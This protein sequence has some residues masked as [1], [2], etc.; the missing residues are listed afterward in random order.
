[1]YGQLTNWLIGNK[2]AWVYL[3]PVLCIAGGEAGASGPILP[4]ISRV[5]AKQSSALETATTARALAGKG[6]FEQAIAL[7]R[8]ALKLAEQEFGPEHEYVAFIL[9][10]LAKLHYQLNS[11]EEALSES[12]RALAII[13]I[14]YPVNSFPYASLAN[15]QASILFALGRLT[16]AERL[17]R[18][19]H[20]VFVNQ[21]G[22]TDP[23]TI[24]TA[25]N[26]GIVY[27]DMS[28]YDDSESFFTKPLRKSAPL[29]DNGVAVAKAT[30]MWPA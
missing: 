21:L 22:V 6:Q 17:Y 12:T 2:R 19:A 14:S 16:E 13:G 25:R 18:Q 1:M 9:D 10:D 8:Q 11:L 27:R 24:T 30:L 3:L 5:A 7:S 29:R 23:S 28:E 4:W 20:D 15:T 26:L